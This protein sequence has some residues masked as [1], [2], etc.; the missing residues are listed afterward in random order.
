MAYHQGRLIDHIH[1][2][3]VDFNRSRDFYG[4]ILDALGRGDCVGR[5]RDWLECDELYIDEINPNEPRSNL[6]LCFQARD[7]AMVDEFYSAAMSNGGR[8]NGSPGP[9]DYHPGYYAAFVLDPD[10][11]NI[12]AKCD[13]RIKKRS[14]DSIEIET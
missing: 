9:R 1:L 12:E 7:R 11:N 2:R 14:A 6:H 5:G 13:E 3:V 4:A 10:G 8:D